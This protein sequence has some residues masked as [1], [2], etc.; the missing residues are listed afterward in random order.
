MTTVRTSRCSDAQ[1]TT[2]QRSLGF[3]FS[4]AGAAIVALVLLGLL[5]VYLVE[6]QGETAAVSRAGT[7]VG[8]LRILDLS[9]APALSAGGPPPLLL[10]GSGP[11]FDDLARI[12]EA[13]RTFFGI[14]LR[15][16]DLAQLERSSRLEQLAGRLV[17]QVVQYDPNGPYILGGWSLSGILAHETAR[18]LRARNKDVALVVLFDPTN[19]RGLTQLADP[20]DPK[21]LMQ[22]LLLHLNRLKDLPLRDMP[23]YVAVEI[24]S[25]QARWQ[26][27]SWIEQY[28]RGA[29][30]PAQ[31]SGAVY[32]AASRYQAQPLDVRVALILPAQADPERIRQSEESWARLAPSQLEVHRVPG[33]HTT[34]FQEPHV[35]VLAGLLR[36]TL[37]A[38]LEE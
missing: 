29:L 6:G 17:D 1:A 37:S 5:A 38:S 32:A 18:Q 12:L 22:R 14:G 24:E 11:A 7:S 20:L 35:Q 2:P 13:D 23:Q 9:A 15:A 27:R 25:L 28:E 3:W 21:V 31:T 34:M 16:G 19:P 8:E 4:R 36:E 26:R 10:V 33:D 30:G